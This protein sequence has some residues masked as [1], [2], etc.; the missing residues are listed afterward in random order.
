[1]FGRLTVTDLAAAP[2]EGYLG[3]RLRV[4]SLPSATA[5]RLI[6]LVVAMLAAGL[7][8]G[9]ALYNSLLG[10]SWIRAV[11]ACVSSA[12]AGLV[13]PVQ[14]QLRCSAPGEQQRALI[15]VAVTVVI[16]LVAVA[17]VLLAPAVLCHRRRLRPGVGFDAATARLAELA[18]RVGVRVPTL[19][20]GPAAQRDAFCFGRPGRYVLALPKALAVRPG[21]P[22]FEAVARHE[23]AHIAHHDVALSWLARSI[24]YALAPA[25]VLPLVLFVGHGDFG[26]GLDYLWRAVV[27]AVVVVLVQRGVL[28]SREHDADLRACD[29]PGVEPVLMDA[30]AGLRPPVGSPARRLL[31]LHPDGSQRQQAIQRPESVTQ[32]SAVDGLTVGFLAT[33]TLPL[34]GSILGALVLANPDALFV[35]LAGTL[36]IGPLLGATLGVALWRQAVVARAAGT[37]PRVAGV[38]LGVLIGTVLGQAVSFDNV[39]LG[40][41]TGTEHPL[42]ALGITF[43]LS[44]STAL[45]AGLGELWSGA[46]G[47][48]GRP[49]GV[50]IPA[51][52]LA[53]LLYAGVLWAA[54]IVQ[55]TWD[56]AGWALASQAGWALA[57]QLP[58]TTL[59]SIPMALLVA[60]MAIATAWALRSNSRTIPA[61]LLPDAPLAP[62]LGPR[63]SH[64]LLAGLLGGVAGGLVL[65][66]YQMIAGLATGDEEVVRRVFAF[67]W[68]AG[69]AGAAVLLGLYLLWGRRGSAAGLLAVP[70]AVATVVVIFFILNWAHGGSL[71]LRDVSGFTRAAL[72]L[73]LLLSVLAALPTLGTNIAR[74]DHRPAHPVLVCMLAIPLAAAA[75]TAAVLGQNTLV[76]FACEALN[77]TTPGPPPDYRV[78]DLLYEQ[79]MVPTLANA[80]TRVA[81]AL[82]AIIKDPS[83]TQPVKAQLLR[84]E[85]VAPLRQSL[86]AA[87]PFRSSDPAV[88]VVHHHA[89]AAL[90]Y[91]VTAYETIAQGLEANSSAILQKGIAERD[92]ANIEWHAWLLGA[93]ALPK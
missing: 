25:L 37:Q 61:W 2:A 56:Q 28:R 17:M 39:G 42:A 19:M 24:W 16:G 43:A 12:P 76:P 15:A 47:R 14:V 13:A 29:G 62:L 84:T 73:G 74:H 50:W 63:V 53:A 21:L 58:P 48:I 89:L 86:A 33:L 52:V 72:V 79:A 35:T 59:A 32:V 1:V 64:V 44:G 81:P 36:V 68:A 57:S 92:R 71:D 93:A 5:L 75:A 4:L 22:V 18:L 6:V 7:F 85:V 49:A 11:E 23:L 51:A 45:L 40:S 60:V 69:A 34:L 54:D 55:N 70:V 90:Q 3:R 82:D 31:A 80:R 67:E 26:L 66:V 8:V 83:T 27:F 10:A 77:P 30:L 78:E 88:N 91:S 65:G 38:V 46:A 41:P 20:V 87:Q 9:T